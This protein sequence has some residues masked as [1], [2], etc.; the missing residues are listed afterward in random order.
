MRVPALFPRRTLFSSCLW[1]FLACLVAY[2]NIYGNAFLWDDLDFIVRNYEIRS[3]SP[4]GKFF[5]SASTIPQR[6]VMNLSFAVDYR[7]WGLNPAGYHLTQVLLHALNSMFVFLFL[8]WLLGSRRSSFLAGLLFALHPVHSEAVTAFLGRSELLTT[9]FCFLAVG[10]FWFSLQHSGV[11]GWLTYLGSLVAFVLACLSKETGIVSPFL[12]ILILW[13]VPKPAGE[14]LRASRAFYFLP[15]GRLL[16]YLAVATFYLLYRHSVLKV[17]AIP[18][19]GGGPSQTFLMM[20]TVIWEYARLLVFPHHLCPWYVTQVSPGFF[21]WKVV[22]GF[23]VLLGSLGLLLFLRK[24]FWVAR[25][26]LGWILLALLPVSNVFPIPGTMMTERWL[27]LPSV[28]FCFVGGWLLAELLERVKA[29]RLM[30]ILIIAFL[31]FLGG[32]SAIRIWTWNP[33]WSSGERLFGTMLLENYE[34]ILAHDR[35]GDLHLE[36]NRFQDAIRDY[37]TTLFYQPKAPRAY[38]GLGSVFWARNLKDEA[39]TLFRQAVILAPDFTQAHYS[40]GLALA[41]TEDTTGAIRELQLV[42]VKE[43]LNPAPNEALGSLLLR[44]GRCGEALGYLK[45]ALHFKPRDHNLHF[46]VA[47][48]LI[49]LGRWSEAEAALKEVLS[50]NPKFWEAYRDLAVVYTNEGRLEEAEKM[51]RIYEGKRNGF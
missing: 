36:H 22:A 38:E 4:L 47:N 49:G 19:W 51:R 10:A 2:A 27:Y 6:P 35:L 3:L 21:P 7:L 44:S 11:R 23:L 9:F 29:L 26:G 1:I 39:L 45:Q 18:W 43:P 34:N 17:M 41:E 37:A 15:F 20:L 24:R 14:R 13:L 8:Y 12:I 31:F 5:H 50:L 33:V 46:K 42:L 16:P 40:L 30:Q 32:L 48:A 25:I 28:G